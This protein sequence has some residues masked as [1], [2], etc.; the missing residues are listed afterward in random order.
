MDEPKSPA[1]LAEAEP[2]RVE[3]DPP[4]AALVGAEPISHVVMME[5]HDRAYYAWKDAGFKDRILVHLDAHL[6]FDWIAYRDPLSLLKTQNLREVE[7]LLA[8]GSRWNLARR[9]VEE[10][11]HVGNYLYPT[12]NDGL[13]RSVYWVVPDQVMESQIERKAL[14]E[15]FNERK[16]KNP[17]GVQQLRW[18]DGKFLAALC[19]KDVTVCRLQDLPDIHEPVLLNIDTDYLVVHSFCD[20]YPYVDP[21]A[22]IPWI[23]PQEL[24]SRLAE[25]GLTTDFVTIAYSVQ[26]GYTPLAFKFLGDDLRRLLEGRPLSEEDHKI[27]RRKQEAVQARQLGKTDETIAAWERALALRPREPAIHYNLAELF[28]E[29][30]CPERAS[31]HYR[32]ATELDPSYRLTED[33]MS[34]VNQIWGLRKKVAAEYQM[35]LA[36]DPGNA[37]AHTW[38]GGLLA[39]QRDWER[40]VSHYN[41]ALAIEPAHA[42]ARY[43]LG[44]IYARHGR[45]EAAER[46]LMQALGSRDYEGLAQFWLGYVYAKTKRWAQAIASY[47]AALRLGNRNLPLHWSLGGL[48]LRT[49]RV[50]KAMRQY[51]RALRM[52]AAV[53]FVLLRRSARHMKNFAR[54]V[55]NGS[56]R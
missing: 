3:L 16:K 14:V 28:Y 15:I 55:S 54:R 6:D 37:D 9:R 25:K 10:L 19:G 44:Y 24:V 36:F 34:P 42:R 1:T 49:G 5:D 30:R 27:L 20:P 50:Y 18:K 43:D 41:K 53:P 52:L 32:R 4:P 56:L 12:L 17:Q 33:R 46:E 48:Y 45:W 26:G 13:V 11:I 7:Q 39:H 23:W 8:E 21:R 40:A 38:L 22:L 2:R 31:A 47:E 35:A 51:R 29:K